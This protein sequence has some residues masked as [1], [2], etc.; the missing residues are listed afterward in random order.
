MTPGRIGLSVFAVAGL[1]SVPAQS[2]TIQVVIDNLEF[3]PPEVTAKVGDTV[4][5]INKDPLAHTATATNGDFNVVIAPKKTG[6]ARL[7][8]A[9]TVDY[10]CTYHPNM[11]GRITIAP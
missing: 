8:K 7:N 4:T 6:Q 1:L 3:T 9:G 5:W 2:A 11:K 10:T